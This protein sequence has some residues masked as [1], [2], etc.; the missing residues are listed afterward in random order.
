MKV[1]RKLLLH[2][3]VSNDGTQSEN[4]QSSTERSRAD[5]FCGLTTME[6]SVTALPVAFVKIKV[7]GS[8]LSNSTFCSANLLKCLRVSCKE[9]R[10]E[11]T[12]MDSYNDVDSLIVTDLE[13]TKLDENIVISLP[14]V[15]SRLPMP[16]VKDEIPKQEDV[17]RRP[18]LQGYVY[19]AELN[20]EVDLL[21]GASVPEALQPREVVPARNGV[22]MQLELILAGLSVTQLEESK[23]LYLFCGCHSFRWFTQV[24]G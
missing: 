4:N 12:T 17:E 11:L 21:I 7:K 10:L 2:P 9:T 24:K 5:H 3:T 14:E 1:H 22:H 8:P 18:H 13:V 20:S 15:L 19:L 6:G 23:S 16:V